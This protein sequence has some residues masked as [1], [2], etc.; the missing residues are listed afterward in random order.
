MSAPSA[1]RARP[2]VQALGRHSASAR[3][4]PARATAAWAQTWAGTTRAWIVQQYQWGIAD[5]LRHVHPRMSLATSGIESSR[6]GAFIFAAVFRK[7]QTGNNRAHLI[8][9]RYRSLCRLA[10]IYPFP[11]LE[12][13]LNCSADEVRAP[14]LLAQDLLDPVERP[15]RQPCRG[16]ILVYAR[17]TH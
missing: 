2:F 4:G 13:P 8:L 3:S 17:A 12:L 9:A 10:R 1:G 15:R 16:V 6:H 7:E 11:P 5:S 14:L